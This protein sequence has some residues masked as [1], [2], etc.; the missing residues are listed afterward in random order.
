MLDTRGRGYGGK[1]CCF[2]LK[3]VLSIMVWTWE[4]P[5]EK[6]KG[7]NNVYVGMGKKAFW[8]GNRKGRR[9]HIGVTF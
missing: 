7:A 4:W 6:R 2:N 1:W 9:P 3:G 5:W 8:N